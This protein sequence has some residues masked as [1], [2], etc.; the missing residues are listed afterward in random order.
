MKTPEPTLANIET[1]LIT[2]GSRRFHHRVAQ[3]SSFFTPNLVR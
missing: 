2:V 3:D 1:K